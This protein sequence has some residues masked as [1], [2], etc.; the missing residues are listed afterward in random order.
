[1]NI[2]LIETAK[3]SR[4]HLASEKTFI[5]S[6]VH[7]SAND[8]YKSKPY[9]IYITN[10]EE[11][12]EGDWVLDNPKCKQ[13]DVCSKSLSKKCICPKEEPK[14]EYQ[15]ECICDTECRKFV[16]VKCKNPKQETLEENSKSHAIYELENNYKPTKE[17]FKLACKRS[18]I[19]G[20]KWQTERMYSEE[21]MEEYA[22]YCWKFSNDNRH[23]SPLSP[24]EW[25]E[26]FKKKE[27]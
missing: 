11:I 2:H 12:K 3:P 16:N 21:Y 23:K 14:Q 26:Q 24:K 9:H 1:M 5:L 6:S 18:F 13:I 20:A 15:S 25:F 27:I 4:L 7:T 19:R 8:L 17:S 22:D 10:D